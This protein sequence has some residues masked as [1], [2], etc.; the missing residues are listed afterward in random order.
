[1]KLKLIGMLF[2]VIG[3]AFVAI[4]L[5][6][7]AL[8]TLQNQVLQAQNFP[9]PGAG[10]PPNLNLSDDQK[11]RLE[12]IHKETKEKIDA[13]LTSEQ[14][15]TLEE[16]AAQMGHSRGRIQGGGPGVPMPPPGEGND[17]LAELNLSNDQKEK[18]QEIAQSSEEKVKSVFTDEQLQQL[19]Q[20]RQN[21]PKRPSPKQGSST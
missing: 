16:K 17:P 6:V 18:I 2:P 5:G 13:V 15:Q 10:Q 8:P 1:M 9:N 3:L 11:Q 20:V 4:P 21:M 19:E 12:E 14:R 7:Q